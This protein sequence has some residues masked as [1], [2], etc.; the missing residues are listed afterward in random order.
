MTPLS[1][2][3]PDDPAEISVASDLGGAGFCVL[4]ESGFENR[5]CAVNDEEKI[6]VSDYLQGLILESSEIESFL[7]ALT[8]LAVHEL[9]EPNEEV[10]CG[11]T[12]LRHKH[13]GTVA[14]S[15]EEAQNLD[16]LQYDYDDG[17][18]LRAARTQSLMHAPDLQDE[19]RW[20]DYTRILLADGIHS[21]L[22]V[23]FHLEQGNHA[24]LNLYATEAHSFT[25]QK[26]RLAQSYADQASQA[27]AIAL[28]L[29]HHQNTAADAIKAMESR[30]T[31]D[32]AVGMIMG[33]NNCSQVKAMEIL[34]SASSSR[35]IKLRDIA[36]AVVRRTN[37]QG[38]TTHF[39]T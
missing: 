26:M 2:V 14:S 34:K 8:R 17:P 33:Q 23:P 27:F 5:S 38:I 36:A 22:A 18:C 24:A 10:L 32:L 31:I 6:T 37:P 12:L 20:P 13:A 3:F 19:T 4:Q 21:V 16:E 29:A 7:N 15:S 39:M 9:S 35:N 25:A 11:I 30:T 28:R 1:H